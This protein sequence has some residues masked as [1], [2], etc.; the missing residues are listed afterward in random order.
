MTPRNLRALDALNFCNAGIQT[1]LGPFISIYYG[2]VRHWDPGRI[3][4]LL[5]CQSLSGVFTQALVGN[6][7]DESKHKRLLTAVAALAVSSGALGIALV[8]SFAAQIVV[9]LIIGLGVTVFP[10]ATAA[11]ALGMVGR[12]ELPRRLARNEVF[13]HSGNVTFAI[14]AGA[15]G[16]LL[17][18]SGIFYA[19]AIFAAG[20][21]GAVVFIREEEVNYEAARGGGDGDGSAAVARRSAR[22][23]FRDRRVLIFTAAVVL[24]NVSNAATLPLVGQLFTKRDHGAGASWQTTLAVLVAEVVMVVAAAIT[25]KRAGDRGR[26]PIFVLAFGVLAVRNALGVVSHEPAYLIA[27]Q[28]F[29]GVAAAIY[30]VLLKLV[31]ADLADGTGRFSF[32]QGTVQSAMGLGGFLSNLAF[33]LVARTMGFNASFLGL[34]GMAVLGGALYAFKMPETKPGTAVRPSR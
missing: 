16:T 22:D 19:A 2:S 20:M 14:I 33:G 11:F 18:L 23:L 27:L 29:D 31:T 5:G 32:L 15:V 3:G 34:S 6:L 28:S 9:Q 1:G 10:A 30:G 17:A 12:D 7:V 25:G 21:A 13:T 26:K 8:P 4:I 24:F